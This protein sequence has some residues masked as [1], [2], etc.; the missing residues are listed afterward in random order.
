MLALVSQEPVLHHGFVHIHGVEGP[1]RCAHA[2]EMGDARRQKAQQV[3]ALG[4]VPQVVNGAEEVKGGLGLRRIPQHRLQVGQD[5]RL[6]E[7][8]QHAGV[9]VGSAYRIPLVAPEGRGLLLEALEIVGAA[10]KEQ[11]ARPG[12]LGVLG[13]Q[14]APEQAQEG[15]ALGVIKV[16]QLFVQAIE[17]QQG[18][19]LPH[20]VQ[21]VLGG[22]AGHAAR[23]E[24]TRQEFLQEGWQVRE[25][26]G[27]LDAGGEI[28]QVQEDG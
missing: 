4:Q 16:D 7:G 20:L 15:L 23:L 21:H 9:V 26:L 3:G 12:R 13:R 8:Q 10:G 22:R 25:P 5:L 1:P 6:M 28:A 18:A 24:G 2:F 17:D 11:L 27:F 19:L 14:G